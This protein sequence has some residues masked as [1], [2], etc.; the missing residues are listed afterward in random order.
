MNIFQRIR[1]SEKI[2]WPIVGVSPMSA[3]QNFST[4]ETHV[5]RWH[6]LQSRIAKRGLLST[7]L[8]VGS[9]TLLVKTFAAG[10]ET[11][12]ARQLGVGDALDTFIV[13]Y[14][15]PALA[16]G[17][18]STSFNSALI[19]TYIQVRQHSGKVAAQQLFSNVIFWSL[20][21]SFLASVLL[22]MLFP[23][24]LPY[25][26]SSFSVEKLN[27]T[28]QLFWTLLPIIAITGLTTIWSAVLNAEGEFV[29]PASAPVITSFVIAGVLFFGTRSGGAWSLAIGTVIG[30]CLEATLIA[31][32]LRRLG[33]SLR[34][35]W[36]GVNADL[37]QVIRQHGP[38]AAA[39]LVFGGMGI[40][41]QAIA[42]RMGPGNVATLN[43]GSKIITMIIGVTATAVSTSVLPHFSRLVANNS[44]ES[45][46]ED[47]KSYTILILAVLVPISLLLFCLSTPLVRIVFERGAFTSYNTK[48]VGHV[49][50]Y[51]ALQIPFYTLGMMYLRLFSAMKL[52]SRIIIVSSVGVVLNLILD[53]V[54]GK[55]FG[56][57]GIALS[58][59][60][61]SLFWSSA[62]YLLLYHAISNTK[63]QIIN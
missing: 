45:L 37:R 2:K 14:Y 59:T 58:T 63:S 11:V 21:L 46:H 40:A 31:L 54:L 48:V 23:L 1:A 22:A 18:I 13:A 44:W 51:F 9:I 38:L 36:Q 16:I 12:V 8:T 10:K 19:P 47:L 27:F 52:N 60:V 39:T 57:A 17:A 25:L 33:V 7:V 4:L 32:C 61:V 50:A 55:Y 6:T 24:I 41:D 3:L 5:L 34:P 15:L 30:A 43:Y 49:Q 35:Q 42:A 29:I 20:G 53:I 28:R 62:S 26:A 56:I